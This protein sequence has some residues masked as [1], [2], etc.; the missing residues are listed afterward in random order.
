MRLNAFKLAALA[1][2]IFAML[3]LL[4]IASGTDRRAHEN[5]APICPPVRTIIAPPPPVAT[6]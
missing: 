4:T 1:A 5:D 3:I 2:F 6:T